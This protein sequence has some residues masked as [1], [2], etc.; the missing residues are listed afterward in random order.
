MKILKSFL[1]ANLICISLN[2]FSQTQRTISEPLPSRQVHLDFHTSEF[3]PG[4]GEKFDKKQ[5]QEALK[6]GH[7]NQIN[8]FAKCH[9]SWS[10]YPTE[11]GKMHPNLKFDL[12]GAEME[13]CHEIGVK[14]PIYFTVGWSA[15]DAE[16]HPEW[17]MRTVSGAIAPESYNFKA[18][19]EDVRPNYSWKRMDASKGSPYHEMI[20]KQVEEICKRYKDLDGFWFDI[21]HVEKLNYNQFAMARMKKEGIDINDP[22]AVERSHALALKAHMKD[23]REL[24]TKYHPKATVFF[25]SA[26][27][28]DDKSIFTERLFDMNTHAELEDLPTTWGGY[29]KLPLEAKYHLQ[30]GTPVV[31]MSGKFHKAWGEFGG[32]K[33]P[34]AIKY[35]AA[36]MIANGV[37]CNFGDQLHP[38]GE[39][40]PE[41]YRNIGEAY[42][43]VEKIEKYGLGGVPVSK[44]GMW[45]TLDNVADHGVV[46]MLLE[47]HDDFIVANEK[48]LDQLELL[49]IPGSNCLTEAQAEK[50][51]GW[52][53]KGGK[54]IVFGKGALD[55]GGKRFVLNVGADYLKKS[56][57]QFDYTVIK[58]DVGKNI[59]TSPFLNYEAGLLVKPT[60]GTT[61]ASIRE[62]YFNRTYAKYNG[63]RETPYKLEDSHYPAVVRNGNVIFFAHNLDQ[64]YYTHGVRMHRELVKNAIDLLYQSPGLKVNN[65]PSCGRVSLLKQEKD[66]RYVAHLLYGPAILRGEVQ[67][68]EDLVPIPGVEIEVNVPEKV[69][70]VYQIPEGKKLSFSRNRNAVRIKV[71]TFTM[72]T[73][74]VLEY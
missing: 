66:K 44:L 59:V 33:H 18:K 25:N 61:L 6:L 24:V 11:V 53:K 54:L 38:S 69:K 71:P 37:S 40:D 35:E 56:D 8:I 1:F 29:D 72:H 7:V 3:I 22:K 13:A 43:Y 52:V 49:V 73:G 27:H 55:K 16:E 47:L 51:N 32:F 9:H 63:H 30:Q 17:T 14:C 21:Y 20:L 39:M 70:N 41:T 57:F 2:G 64:L 12:L 31:A 10:Y 45:L 19:P 74:I 23:L 15:R 65:L 42:K 67:V 28:L 34:D 62:P 4:I 50:I 68:I 36:A 5:F 58:Q 60:T 26:T 46:N 48:N